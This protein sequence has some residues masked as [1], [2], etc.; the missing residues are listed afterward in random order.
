M[1]ADGAALVAWTESVNQLWQVAA[2]TRQVSGGSWSAPTVLRPGDDN[3]NR[4]P[5][6][7][8]SGTG[9]GFVLWTQDDA[10]GWISVWMA[11]HT[12]AGWQPTALFES[13]ESQSASSPALA[14]NKA[15]TVIGSYVQVTTTVD[16]LWTRRYTPGA[17]FA[18]PLLAGQATYIE[19]LVF[20][21][22]TLDESGVAT[23]AYAATDTFKGKNQVYA[24]RAGATAT[25]WPTP[26]MIESNNDAA[27]DDPN[28]S[29]ARSPMPIVRNDAAGN[30]TLIWRKRTGA[31][32]DLYG[33]RFAAGGT[34]WGA[35]TLLE[36]RDTSSIFFPALGV[37]QGASNSTAIA[38]WNYDTEPDVWANVYR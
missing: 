21:S 26:T 18:A 9:E 27:P 35:P 14:T 17:G 37:S 7:V 34:A 11:Q 3:G 16:Q 4:E 8:V 31:R 12:T 23:V 10:A 32:F 36:T 20:P 29:I 6:A 15:G 1:N 5:V 25:A 28:S 13:Y 33:Q 22:V 2:A 38:V 30:V 19:D 24:N